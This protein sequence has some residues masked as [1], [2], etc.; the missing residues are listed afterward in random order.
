M[1]TTFLPLNSVLG[2]LAPD[3][4]F[5]H[6]QCISSLIRS[7][8]FLFVTAGPGVAMIVT[9]LKEKTVILA[10]GSLDDEHQGPK[11]ANTRPD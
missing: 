3:C 2:Q 1:R 4:V 8:L 11:K 9:L 6:N 5:L 10:L 7:T